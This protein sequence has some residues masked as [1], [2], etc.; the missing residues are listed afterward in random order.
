MGQG[1]NTCFYCFQ[2]RSS[3][4]HKRRT[5]DGS[6][7]KFATSESAFKKRDKKQIKKEKRDTDRQTEE[8]V[9]FE[10]SVDGG[11]GGN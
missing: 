9:D 10:G 7:V 1:R 3:V 2:I 6:L 5:S 4:H 8:R 11:D